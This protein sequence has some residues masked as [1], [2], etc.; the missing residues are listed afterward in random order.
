[1]PGTRSVLIAVAKEVFINDFHSAAG[2]G[3]CPLSN[4]DHLLVSSVS[5]TEP[6]PNISVACITAFSVVTSKF[7]Y[8]RRFQPIETS[9][10]WKSLVS[11]RPLPLGSLL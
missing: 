4:S 1:M 6:Q 7:L 2:G 11:G 3:K 5:P 8:S 10:Q 9:Y